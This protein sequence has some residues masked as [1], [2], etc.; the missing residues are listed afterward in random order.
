MKDIEKRSDVEFLVDEFYKEV[1]EDEEIGY[2]FNEVIKLD[3]EKHIP[4]MYDFWDSTLL[5]AMNYK[6][7]PMVKHISLDKKS[8]MKSEHFQRWL[9]LWE[10]TLIKNFRGDKADEAL[11]RAKHISKLIEY[12]ISTR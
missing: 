5:G 4:I 7:N 3:W 1:V 12:N 2:F 11:N 6:G 9:H 10:Q 8:Q